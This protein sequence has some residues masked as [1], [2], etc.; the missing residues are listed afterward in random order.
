MAKDGAREEV[1]RWTLVKTCVQIFMSAD[2]SRII[3]ESERQMTPNEIG[4]RI[5][6]GRTLSRTDR[7]QAGGQ[8]GDATDVSVTTASERRALTVG[9]TDGRTRA[10]EREFVSKF[11]DDEP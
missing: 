10:R 9:Q 8:A 3:N 1:S 11:A 7:W 5:T 6:N 2:R 4:R